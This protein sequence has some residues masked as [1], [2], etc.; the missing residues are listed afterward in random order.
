MCYLNTYFI[1]QIDLLGPRNIT[2][3][4]T[5]GMPHG[6]DIETFIPEMWVESYR[7]LYSPDGIGWNPILD[8]F[9]KEKV[10]LYK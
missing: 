9:G 8:V 5:K 4:E 3:I 7:L 1:F 10:S 6:N 2:G